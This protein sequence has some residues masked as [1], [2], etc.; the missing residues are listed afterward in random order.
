MINMH[1]KGKFQRNSATCQKPGSWSLLEGVLSVT[2]FSFKEMVL[3]SNI[4]DS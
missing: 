1:S 4:D 3:L 2:L